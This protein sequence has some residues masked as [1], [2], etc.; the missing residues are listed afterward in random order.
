[1]FEDREGKSKEIVLQ[2]LLEVLIHADLNS[3]K[4]Y[5]QSEVF[6]LIYEAAKDREN[7]E[8]PTKKL[9]YEILEKMPGFDTSQVSSP[10]TFISLLNK[11]KRIR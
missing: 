4:S 9:I 10:G 2:N 5:Q 6:D 11:S 1:M 8:Y 3:F 7:L